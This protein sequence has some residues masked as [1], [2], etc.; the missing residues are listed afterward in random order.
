MADESMEH[1]PE[2]SSTASAT[3]DAA[4]QRPAFE[5][6]E[7]REFDEAIRVLIEQGHQGL[8]QRII[9][10]LDQRR[11]DEAMRVLNDDDGERYG[12][13]ASWDPIL[14]EFRRLL[15]H[16][17]RVFR[18]SY[19]EHV[20][21]DVF[22]TL[23]LTVARQTASSRDYDDDGPR[24][25]SNGGFGAVPAPAAAV[26]GLE[27][28]TFHAG[29]AEGCGGGAVTECSICFEGFV[30]G[31][32]VSVMPCPSRG[33]EF[34]TE[35]IVKWLGVSNMCPLCRHGL[36]NSSAPASS[37]V[38]AEPDHHVMEEVSP[39]DGPARVERRRS[40]TRR[41]QPNVRTSGSEWV[42]A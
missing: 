7:Q 21:F 27:K 5:A 6:D 31:G 34:H 14:G 37:M 25:Y 15:N 29:A 20:T 19:D 36:G 12:W 17:V 28:R 38:V 10:I 33:H 39:Q 40:S 30:D 41:R 32:E 2:D 23:V 22:H 26:A 1:S 16:D 3:A 35:C 24:Y 9:L 13:E 8:V 18:L 11:L 4:H 42:R